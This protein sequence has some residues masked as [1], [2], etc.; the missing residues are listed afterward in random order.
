MYRLLNTL[1]YKV[2]D[3]WGLYLLGLSTAIDVEATEN[4]LDL[5]LL[6]IDA[7]TSDGLL[8]AAAGDCPSFFLSC[9]LSLCLLILLLR[10]RTLEE[11]TQPHDL[12]YELRV[13]GE[14]A[15]TVIFLR[16]GSIEAAQLSWQIC[17]LVIDGAFKD[18]SPLNMCLSEQIMWVEI[19]YKRRVMLD[20]QNRRFARDTYS[21][22]RHGVGGGDDDDGGGNKE[23]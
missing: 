19:F 21:H 15:T 20:Q 12:P 16:R 4:L 17:H 2:I 5:L 14:L 9:R 1:L 23:A 3:D 6:L 8:I 13:G 18:L 11:L 10:L 7:A 22:S